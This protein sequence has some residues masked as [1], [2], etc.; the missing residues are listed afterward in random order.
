MR[1]SK[2]DFLANF[3]AIGDQNIRETE[4]GFEIVPASEFQFSY[5]NLNHSDIT[6]PSISYTANG[7]GLYNMSG[8]VSEL[9]SDGKARGGSWAS[10]GFD[11]RVLSEEEFFHAN[12]QT[13][14]RPVITFLA[15]EG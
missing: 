5:E 11:I 8:N 15:K 9:T 4:N 12:P 7:Y 14:F 1:D 6:A 3:K 10:T 13:G 2:G